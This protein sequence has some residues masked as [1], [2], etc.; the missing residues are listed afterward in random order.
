[1]SINEDDELWKENDEAEL[2]D[3]QREFMTRGLEYLSLGARI[4]PDVIAKYVQQLENNSEAPVEYDLCF[5]IGL[6]STL[7]AA[8]YVLMT[9]KGN[10]K[11]DLMIQGFQEQLQCWLNAQGYDSTF[12]FQIKPKAT[13]A[14]EV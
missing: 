2:D 8:Y 3:K 12:A 14:P 10:N 11:G 7:L 6:A 13:N 9:K 5:T 4:G 1:M